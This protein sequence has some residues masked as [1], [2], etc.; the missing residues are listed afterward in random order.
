[1][2]FLWGPKIGPEPNRLRG[3]EPNRPT[4][5]FFSKL[6]VWHFSETTIEVV[7]SENIR[8]YG[9]TSQ[10]NTLTFHNFENKAF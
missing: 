2:T 1:M 5:P 6:A 9:Q 7:L 10:Q 4:W 8:S 3:P